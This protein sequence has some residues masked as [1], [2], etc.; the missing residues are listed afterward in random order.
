MYFLNSF[1]LRKS[2][3]LESERF[4]RPRMWYYSTVSHKKVQNLF[5][6]FTSLVRQYWLNLFRLIIGCSHHFCYSMVWVRL[7]HWAESLQRP[8]LTSVSEGRL[9]PPEML[10]TASY[11]VQ[12][13]P[14]GHK[15]QNRICITCGCFLSSGTDNTWVLCMWEITQRDTQTCR[16]WKMASR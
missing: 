15:H 3:L 13:P 5:I 2:G 6:K 16:D 1:P 10:R 9:C 14:D 12:L 4:I 11:N 8:S 7:A